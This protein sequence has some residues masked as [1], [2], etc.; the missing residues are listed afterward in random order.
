LAHA[1]D[2]PVTFQFEVD[3][4]G[5]GEWTPLRTVAVPAHGYQWLE[6][7]TAAKGAWVRLSANRDCPRATAMF[8]FSNDDARPLDADPIFRAWA[9]FD[10]P[11]SIYTAGLL[12]ARG[13]DRRSLQVGTYELGSD[14][15]LRLMDDP[16]ADEWLRKNLAIPTR[17]LTVEPSSI[18]YVDDA[19]QRWRLPKASADY[20]H[21]GPFGI[22]RV[23]REVVTERDLFNAGGTFYELP[24]EN[25]GGFAKIRPIAT[26]G[27]HIQDY[28]SWRGL[29]VVSGLGVT[30]T[31]DPHVI[32]S[33]DGRCAVWVG[34]V[35]DL[36]KL[37]KPH[38]VG[39]PWLD[40]PVRKGQPSDPY[41][42]TG[43][44]QKRLTL[45]HRGTSDVTIRIEVDISGTGLWQTYRTFTI[46]PHASEMH[47]FPPGFGAYWLRVT[48][49]ADVNATA[50][51]RY[52]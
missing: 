5:R 44:D 46:P 22:E 35:D 38:G 13:D 18:L 41:L 9:R 50:Q 52:E 11:Q 4:D 21:P 30:A 37:G 10:T 23:D 40:T 26:H 49:D 27:L 43:F 12:H 17:V 3:R 36:W 48:A 51:L 45:S 15:T 47:S 6:F 24:A 29:L 25:T 32:R 39:G 28:C 42:M 20:T 8:E 14:M 16:S 34:A 7:D 19:G 1:S 33:A 2:A 31:D